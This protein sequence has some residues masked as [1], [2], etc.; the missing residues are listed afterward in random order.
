MKVVY[1]GECEEMYGREI[2]VPD[3]ECIEHLEH[4]QESWIETHGLDCGPYEHCYEEWH[5]CS[6]CGDKFTD[7]EL[8][9]MV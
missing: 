3:H 4:R 2:E 1:R 8:S 5:E 7:D 6:V 9:R